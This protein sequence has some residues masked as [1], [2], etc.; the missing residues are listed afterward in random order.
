[1]F[2]PGDNEREVSLRLL[3]HRLETEPL[4]VRHRFLLDQD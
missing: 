1:M 3:L 2:R 4:T